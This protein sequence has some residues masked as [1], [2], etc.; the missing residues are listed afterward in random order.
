M[1]DYK[2]QEC[3]PSSIQAYISSANPSNDIIEPFPLYI[4]T[5]HNKLLKFTTVSNKLENALV[6]QTGNELYFHSKNTRNTRSI[7]KIPKYSKQSRNSCQKQFEISKRL[8]SMEILN[9][10][11]VEFP[12]RQWQTT[13][14]SSKTI[15]T[16]KSIK[17][18]SETKDRT[19]FKMHLKHSQ[20][21]M[22]KFDAIWHKKECCYVTL[23]SLFRCCEKEFLWM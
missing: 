23:R 6:G 1:G 18:K 2:S 19:I 10:A 22:Q 14:Q 12:C 13:V 4:C 8:V 15:I 21:S 9:P 17:D 11:I 3:F 20:H 7:I 16:I 5:S